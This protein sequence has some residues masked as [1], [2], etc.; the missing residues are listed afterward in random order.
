MPVDAQVLSLAP[1][2]RLQALPKGRRAR[3]SFWI[4][5]RIVHQHCDS[6]H[7]VG[8]LR[9]CRNWP[10]R[11]AAEKS[12]ELSPPHSITSLAS[13]STLGGMTRPSAL[14]VLRLMTS[15]NFESCTT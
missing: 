2:E 5:L 3:L 10:R 12:D 9:A 7:P 11:R 15:S 4:I 14:P 8:L 13:A 6:A 1:T